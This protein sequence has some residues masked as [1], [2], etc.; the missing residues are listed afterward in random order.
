ML[1][2]ELLTGTRDRQRTEKQTDGLWKQRDVRRQR[3]TC[4]TAAH[5]HS[6]TSEMWYRQH[7]NGR[8]INATLIIMT[9]LM[10]MI[11]M[12]C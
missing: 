1:F 3:Q 10:T 7:V 2:F 4:I 12:L 5:S 6:I 9:M 8:I 11:M